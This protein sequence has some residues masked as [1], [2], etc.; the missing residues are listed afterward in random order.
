M[1]A[2]NNKKYL[3]KEFVEIKKRIQK[4]DK[5]YIEIG[6]H[7]LT[8]N[9]AKRVLPGY[10]PK[11]KLKLIKKLPNKGFVY[12]VNANTL[13]KGKTW[14]NTTKTIEEI[15]LKEIELLKKEGLELLCV[16]LSLYSHAKKSSTFKKKLEKKGYLVLTTKKI[17]NYP[18]NLKEIMGKNGFE[19]QPFLETKKNNIIV[20]GIGANSGKLFFCLSQVFHQTKK[21]VNAGYFKIETFPVWNLSLDHELNLAYEAATADIQDKLTIDKFHK[22]KYGILA[23]NY[24]RDIEAFSVLKKLINKITRKE[25]KMRKYFSPTDMGINFVKNGIIDDEKVRESSRK[26]ILWRKKNFEKKF[27]EKQVNKKTL[28]RMNE[29]IKKINKKKLN[30]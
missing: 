25:N 29:I 10:N 17:K 23:V 19:K 9:H 5:T 15:S 21:G 20:T 6:G 16:V 18:N 12:C 13:D 8:D 14:G 30:S 4:F 11:N 24:N 22:K 26:E 1:N 27:K 3:E 2:F 28:E 7:L